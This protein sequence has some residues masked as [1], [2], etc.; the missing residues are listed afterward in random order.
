M[1]CTAKRSPF[2]PLFHFL[3]DIHNIHTVRW[4]FSHES[5]SSLTSHLYEHCHELFSS[6]Q[7]C[8]NTACGGRGP[9]GA[10]CSGHGECACGRCRCRP[11]YTGDDC[12][13][14]V[15]PDE[16]RA[17]ETPNKVSLDCCLQSRAACCVK[18]FVICFLVVPLACLG[19]MAA[20]VQPNSLWNSQK[21]C[22]KT[23]PTTC[24]PRLHIFWKYAVSLSYQLACTQLQDGKGLDIKD[25]R[26]VSLRKR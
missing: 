6:L 22:Y 24:R 20:A 26:N 25:Q 11:R 10:L 13:C 2:G 3:C 7:V 23:F 19:S 18:G 12:E 9:G 15:K 5:L 14:R 17:P 8:D 16:C 4:E 21:T 1:S